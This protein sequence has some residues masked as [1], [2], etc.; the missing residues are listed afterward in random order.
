M[1][2]PVTINGGPDHTVRGFFNQI[3]KFLRC[4]KVNA[5]LTGING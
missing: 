4:H 5:C 3:S 1:K 2:L